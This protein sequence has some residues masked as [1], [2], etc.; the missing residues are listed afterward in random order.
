MCQQ[1]AADSLLYLTPSGA[2]PGQ[3]WRGVFFDVLW[4][5][6]T[7]WHADDNNDQESSAAAVTA[8]SG[9]RFSI[10]VAARFC[11]KRDRSLTGEQEEQGDR[12]VL[13][14]HQQ[15]Q[16]IRAQRPGISKAA[17]LRLI[18]SGGRV[19]SDPWANAEVREEEPCAQAAELEAQA[20]AKAEAEGD[21]VE[22]TAEV[23]SMDSDACSV[24]TMAP[25][26]GLRSFTYDAL[27]EADVEQAA[28]YEGTARRMVMDVINGEHAVELTSACLHACMHACLHVCMY[29]G[30]MY[31]CMHAATSR[32]MIL[33]LLTT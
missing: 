2:C 12:V 24:L 17:A 21:V 11:P 20:D 5:A 23:L 22:R 29:A 27:F 14:L 16:M 19:D 30:C 18:T 28:V 33:R 7:L 26:V 8:H 9:D 25:G 10:R 15:L 3:S 6:R 1:L 13:P 32:N 31:A 4:P